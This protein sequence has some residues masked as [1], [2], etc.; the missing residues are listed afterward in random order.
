MC[1]Y[2]I[3]Q[4]GGANEVNLANSVG[5]FDMKHG[6]GYLSQLRSG[7]AGK[8]CFGEHIYPDFSFSAIVLLPDHSSTSKKRVPTESMS[9]TSWIARRE[10]ARSVAL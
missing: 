7:C 1:L 5:N 3:T 10:R 8:D 6:N 9:A 4:C 2:I